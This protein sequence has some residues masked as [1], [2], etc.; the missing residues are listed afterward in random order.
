[1]SSSTTS[2]ITLDLHG[3]RARRG[4]D[5]DALQ[6]FVEQFRRALREFERARSGR[7]PV[8]RTGRPDSV[9]EHVTAF[10][11]VSLAPGSAIAVLE[12]A[13]SEGDEPELPL[14]PV[15]TAALANLRSLLEAIDRASALDPVVIGALDRARRALGDDGRFGVRL[16]DRAP[17]LATR[18]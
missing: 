15:P 17:T 10:R 1:M 16:P 11:L 7:S 6:T 14:G 2:P 8:P 18:T 12:A 4:I 9:A 5:L 13:P 3:R